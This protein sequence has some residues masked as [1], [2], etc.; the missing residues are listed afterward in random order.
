MDDALAKA[1]LDDSSKF[2][3]AEGHRLVEVSSSGTAWQ[4]KVMQVLEKDIKATFK[5]NTAV[6]ESNSP[7]LS[8]PSLRLL[9][10]SSRV[11]HQNIWPLP[12]SSDSLKAVLDSL[13]IPSIFLRA[14]CN[15]IP[16]ATEF[17]GSED[18]RISGYLLRT[19]LSQTWQ[20][21]LAVSRDVESNC[22]QGII[23]GLR[24]DEIDDLLHALAHAPAAAVKSTIAL[25]TMI[26]DMAFDALAKDA[27][28][29]RI[30]LL[31]LC[32]DTGLHG[33]QRV[34]FLH[35]HHDDRDE[36]DLDVTMSKLTG[37]SDAC[38]GISAVCKMQTVFIEVLTTF[39]HQQQALASSG[40]SRA[41]Y[42]FSESAAGYASHSQAI[43][44]HAEQRL[45]FLGQILRGIESKVLYVGSSVQGQIQTIYTLIE[46]RESQSHYAL[47]ETT[48]RLA[49]LT[50]RDSTDMRTIAAVTL[51]FLPATFTATFFST[52]F[53]SFQG[54]ASVSSWIWLYW[55]ITAVLTGAVLCCW[56]VATK[57]QRKKAIAAMANEEKIEEKM[58]ERKISFLGLKGSLNEP[59]TARV[60]VF[61][62]YLSGSE[63]GEVF[64][65]RGMSISFRSSHRCPE[66]YRS[67]R[68][69]HSA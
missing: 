41:A 44:R 43:R 51:V 52:T 67:S 23:M 65:R 26:M 53:F 29:R 58:Q 35:R 50:Q 19:N 17:E 3:P 6:S 2:S 15:H 4:L 47:A 46:Q 49:E 34:S 66:K 62:P 59:V 32:Y 37:L 24:S 63:A 61:R 40:Q 68:Q 42:A 27:E 38:A 1:L 8:L 20:Y 30:S 64:A 48:R 57:L 39:L 36:L 11:L 22:L 9:V 33:F 18:R 56:W 13:S 55:L 7:R 16:L 60:D 28:Q 54:G 31:K 5:A 25:P 45:H 21:A 12:C 14:V 10:C 69:L